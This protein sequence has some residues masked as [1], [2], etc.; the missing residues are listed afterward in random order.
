MTRES[1]PR[2]I[3][4]RLRRGE[5]DDG[6]RTAQ[7]LCSPDQRASDSPL[8]VRNTDGQI[9]QIRGVTEI[10]QAPRDPHQQ[11]IVPRRHDEVGIRQH[12]FHSLAIIHRPSLAQRRSAI[13][14]DD[15]IKVEIVPCPISDH[16]TRCEK[17]LPLIA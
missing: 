2:I 11:I 7:F 4:H 14:F 6:C 8:L 9:R 5:Q 17:P 15:C 3:T 16:E 13:Q 1:D 12:E 10:T